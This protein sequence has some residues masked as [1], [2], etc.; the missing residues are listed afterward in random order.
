MSAP[1]VAPSL[2]CKYHEHDASLTTSPLPRPPAP[3]LV[4]PTSVNPK[5]PGRPGKSS[6]N[7]NYVIPSHPLTNSDFLDAAPSRFD[8]IVT[9]W[10]P[11]KFFLFLFS[12]PHS[13]NFFFGD[14]IYYAR[15]PAL[16]SETCDRSCPAPDLWAVRTWSSSIA[17]PPSWPI[18][19][20]LCER[21]VVCSYRVPR[22]IVFLSS[23]LD[24]EH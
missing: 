16:P 12:C 22:I 1:G 20:R 3:G 21:A 2:R 5:N 17:F 23:L 15:R 6:P 24:L 19:W 7:H 11:E 9:N 10:T 4:P 14:Y 13:W 18:A 8:T